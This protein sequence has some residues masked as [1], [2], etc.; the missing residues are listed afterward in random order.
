V[1]LHLLFG[2]LF[3]LVGLFYLWFGFCLLLLFSIGFYIIVCDIVCSVVYVESVVHC[4]VCL[5]N[6]FSTISTW[7][8]LRL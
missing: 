8:S 1:F 7:L 2:S 6:G 3:L 4:F 5:F